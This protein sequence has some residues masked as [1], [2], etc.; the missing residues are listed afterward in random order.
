MKHALLAIALAAATVCLFPTKAL[1]Y[2][3]NGQRIIYYSDSSYTV[4]VGRRYVCYGSMFY[5]GKTSRYSSG[6]VNLAYCDEIITE[7][8]EY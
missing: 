4:D 1:A 3:P 7:P 8:F 6:G 2:P 5:Y